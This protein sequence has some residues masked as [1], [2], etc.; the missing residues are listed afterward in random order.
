MN[1]TDVGK[2][3]V[4]LQTTQMDDATYKNESTNDTGLEND[5]Q[6]EKEA[7]MVKFGSY[8]THSNLKL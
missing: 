2:V 3:S 4:D 6:F 1:I 5:M 8:G 7:P